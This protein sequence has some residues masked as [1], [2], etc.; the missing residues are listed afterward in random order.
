MVRI[1]QASLQK[2]FP[3]SSLYL[4]DCVF[5]H[6]LPTVNVLTFLCVCITATHM[7]MHMCVCV[8][9]TAGILADRWAGSTSL[10]KSRSLTN[11]PL[12]LPPSPSSSPRVASLFVSL[13]AVF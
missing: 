2:L 7:H 1:I 6:Y 4:S 12:S 3:S 10:P 9:R 8:F 11:V 5:I 13:A